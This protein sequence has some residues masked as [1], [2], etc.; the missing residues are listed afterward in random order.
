M[1]DEEGQ[2]MLARGMGIDL[3]LAYKNNK[4][5]LSPAFQKLQKVVKQRI[6]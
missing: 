6:A 3:N 5:K 1:L 2:A 4:T